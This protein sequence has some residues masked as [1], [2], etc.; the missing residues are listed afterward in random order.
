[1]VGDFSVSEMEVAEAYLNGVRMD[2]ASGS[3]PLAPG[4]NIIEITSKKAD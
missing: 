4:E 3:V 2:A 1:M